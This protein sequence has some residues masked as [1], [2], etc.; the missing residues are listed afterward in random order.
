MIQ[1]RF[2]LTLCSSET[3]NSAVWSSW[4]TS[5]HWGSLPNQLSTEQQWA[6]YLIF[7]WFEP[8]RYYVKHWKAQWLMRSV[9]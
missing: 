5:G 8:S 7:K 3:K 1:K 9:S 4:G 6:S 2:I